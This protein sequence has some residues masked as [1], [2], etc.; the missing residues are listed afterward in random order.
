MIGGDGFSILK[1]FDVSPKKIMFD[2][3]FHYN[4]EIEH[5]IRASGYFDVDIVNI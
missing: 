1:C 4:H 2:L 3:F 5:G